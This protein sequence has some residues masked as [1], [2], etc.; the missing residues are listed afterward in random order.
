MKRVFNL[1]SLGVAGFYQLHKYKADADGNPIPETKTLVCDWFPN[2]ITNQGLERM[3]T[4]NFYFNMCQVGSGN[5]PPAV[6]DTALETYV[7]GTSTK[8]ST[9]LA[10]QPSAPYYGYCTGTYRFEA[11]VAAGN[12]SEV[13]V[14]W[15]TSGATLFSRALILDGGG[16]PT[17]I[18]I[19]SDEILDVTYQFRVYPPL[20]DVAGSINISGTPHSYVAR[21]A[22]VTQVSGQFGQGW[23]MGFGG[24]QM[25][26]RASNVTSG[27]AYTGGLGP[28]TGNPSGSSANRNIVT[29]HAYVPGSLT[30]TGEL[31]WGIGATN[32][33]SYRSVTVAFT[34]CVFQIEYD[35]VIPKTTINELKL[36]FAVSWGRATIP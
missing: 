11:G 1:G 35:P 12:L 3:G 34:G 31:T 29:A 13:G 7:A 27:F 15:G 25:A 19:L 5:T 26:I 21:A 2:L 33:G 32:I 36:G 9:S 22:I 17:T 4:D 18:T 14:G 28:I 30:A 20:D 10:T 16:N 23:G 6:T 24:A 8:H